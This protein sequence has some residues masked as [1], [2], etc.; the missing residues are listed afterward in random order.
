MKMKCK[1]IKFIDKSLCTCEQKIAYNYAVAWAGVYI[2]STA[3][4]TSELEKSIV[5]QDI[6]DIIIRDIKSKKEMEKYNI[7]AIIVAFRNGF[8]QY[9]EN[10]FI[11]FHY[12]EIGNVFKI[13]YEIE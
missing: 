7:D 1:K 5:V 3:S 12:N 2:R 4:M 8:K 9:C 13:P 11:P 6:I 10:I